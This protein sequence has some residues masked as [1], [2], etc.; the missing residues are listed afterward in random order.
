MR[1]N[2]QETVDL[3]TLTEETLNA[4]L[5]FLC[6]ALSAFFTYDTHFNGVVFISLALFNIRS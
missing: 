1:T 6:S 5:H 4:K 3:V 2:L